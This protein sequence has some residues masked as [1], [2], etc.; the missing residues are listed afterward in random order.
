MLNNQDNKNIST[1]SGE[2]ISSAKNKAKPQL[3]LDKKL[4]KDLKKKKLS[5]ALRNNLNRRKKD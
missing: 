2:V 4:L 1:D 3:N 5:Q